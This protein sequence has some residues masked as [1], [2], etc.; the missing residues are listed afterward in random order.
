VVAAVS[1]VAV[2]GSNE[3]LA[4]CSLLALLAAVFMFATRVLR[5]ASRDFLSRTV[6]TGFLRGRGAGGT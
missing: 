2:R 5:L 4:L 6:L 3:W 1:P